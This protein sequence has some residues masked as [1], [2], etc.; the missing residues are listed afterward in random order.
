[1]IPK[2]IHYC[3]FSGEDF[4]PFVNKCINTWKKVL[5]EYRLRL[6]DSDSI[7]EL[8]ETVPFVREAYKAR[9]WAFVTDYVRLYALYTE[10]GIYMDTD[11]KVMR[12]FNEFLHYG[13][14]TSHELQPRFFEKSE[15]EKIDD[16][17]RPLS[18]D[19]FIEG[20]GIQGAIMG[21]IKGHPFL[22]D[23]LE[24]YNNLT[25]DLDKHTTADY[26]IGK[27]ISRIAANDYG[28]RYT[29]E[30]QH[31]VSDMCIM[32]S[33]IIVGNMLYLK[34]YSYAIHLCN[35]SWVEGNKDW[36]WQLR[37]HHTIIHTIIIPFIKIYHKMVRLF[38]STRQ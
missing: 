24:Y 30:E 9:K 17:G 15:Q 3:W 18:F 16:K 10:G 23:C 35:G 33:D 36:L 4:P 14:F 27:Q 37:N 21:A 13:F 12:S 22:R 32:R 25:F 5:P 20:M 11:V 28:Y 29:D 2:V 26:V 31:L 1:M 6:W 34:P 38:N 19:V 8:I 7:K